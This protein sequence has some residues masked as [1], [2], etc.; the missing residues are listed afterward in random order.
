[1][2]APK[3]VAQNQQVG[4]EKGGGAG[5]KE[6]KRKSVQNTDAARAKSNSKLRKLSECLTV[7]RAIGK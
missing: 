5:R 6:N 7:H 1:V 2:T 4:G 3:F